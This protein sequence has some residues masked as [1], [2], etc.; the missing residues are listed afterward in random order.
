MTWLTEILL[1][2][3]I[4]RIAVTMNIIQL[5]TSCCYRILWAFAG[6]RVQEA[7]AARARLVCLRSRLAELRCL[8]ADRQQRASELQERVAE[9]EVRP[10]TLPVSPTLHQT[11]GSAVQDF[12]SKD[13]CAVL[14]L[15]VP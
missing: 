8:N 11:F 1:M 6:C 10:Q 2:E 13:C 7:T 14:L 3:R 4:D 5:Q 15:A 9:T 12:T